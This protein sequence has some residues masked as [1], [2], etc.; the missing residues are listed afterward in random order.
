MSVI[1]MPIAITRTIFFWS[2][3]AILQS[4]LKHFVFEGWSER[5]RD[6]HTKLN[7]QRRG[8]KGKVSKKLERTK[9]RMRDRASRPV[10]IKGGTYDFES[11]PDLGS[12]VG[13]QDNVRDVGH[14]PHLTVYWSCSIKGVHVNNYGQKGGHARK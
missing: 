5:M 6:V 12:I 14:R 10:H 2:Q 1:H 8:H 4:I 7:Q 9:K 3:M 11:G 13:K